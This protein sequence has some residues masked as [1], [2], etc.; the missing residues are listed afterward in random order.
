M[1]VELVS[2]GTELLLGDILNTNVQY[3]SR[4]LANYGFDIFHSSVVGDNAGRLREEIERAMSRSDLLILT[5]GLG[6]TSDDITKRVVID[7]VGRETFEDE[8]S[9]NVIARWFSHPTAME[10]NRIS[11]TFPR[12]SHILK[13]DVGIASG[14]LIP[15]GDKAIAIL[16]GPPREMIPMFDNYLLPILKVESTDTI[17][18][19]E[20]KIG[21]LG[22]YKA[23]QRLEELIQTSVNPTFAPYAKEDGAIIRITAKAENKEKADRL[24]QEGVDQARSVY[25]EL[26]IA[27]NGLNRKEVL[28]DLL[29]TRKEKVTIAESI[30]GGLLASMI[31]D[32]AGASEVI[33][34]SYV[35][36]S[37]RAKR[38]ILGVSEEI[39]DKH[40]AVSAETVR[41][42]VEGLSGRVESDLQIATTGYAGPTGADVGRV[43]LAIR[44]KNQTEIFEYRLKGNREANRRRAAYLAID[45]AIMNMRRSV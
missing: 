20:L 5:G 9:K 13:N 1:I 4:E 23:Y 18:S 39:L 6:A 22:E 24:V 10:E 43:L 8:H 25:G 29:K 15:M 35:V 7:Y 34:E 31:T 3:L 16:P 33:E 14:A 37:D 12:D 40:T 21:L 17:E 42:M 38:E 19:V 27:E 2:V 44:Y 28:V 30:S 36:Y 41:A 11:Y 45:H 32:V 26:I